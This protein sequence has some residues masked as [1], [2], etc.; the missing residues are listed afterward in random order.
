S[1]MHHGADQKSGNVQLFRRHA[2]FDPL[3]GKRA[4]VPFLSGNSIR[5]LWRDMVMGRWLQLLGLKA[6]DLPTVRAH[7]LLAGGAVAEGA[8][9]A[10]VNNA[11][12]RRARE[13]C[14]PWDLLAG[15]TDQQIMSGRAR[16]S[17]AT[18]VC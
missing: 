7:A 13:L 2:V 3:T 18:L 1:P 15:C 6:S 17:D 8:D 16:V 12:R 4:F 11:V 14:P 9:G 5:G 10:T